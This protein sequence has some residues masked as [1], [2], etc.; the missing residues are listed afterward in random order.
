[1]LSNVYKDGII[2]E[3]FEK[4]G[5]ENLAFLADG[6][7]IPAGKL[8][9]VEC[10]CVLCQ[11][12]KIVQYRKALLHNPY[13]CQRCNFSGEKNPFFGKTHTD[14]FKKRISAERKAN[15]IGEKN[16]FFGKHHSP[17]SIAL[18]KNKCSN[19][20]EK[21]GFFGKTHT[22][23]TR[24]K[25]SLYRKNHPKPREYYSNMG[26][27]SANKRPKKTSIEKKVEKKLGE[28]GINHRYSFILHKKAQYDFLIDENILL[29]VHGDYWHGNPKVYSS[30][31]E[32]QLY[33]KSRDIEKESLAKENDYLYYVIWES[34]INTGNWSILNEI[35]TNRNQNVAKTTL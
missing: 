22:P 16:P 27:I 1:M 6:R 23:E 5:K 13:T 29:E 15:Y 3:K 19:W 14:E 8:G 30:F 32:R 2:I 21:N 28:L 4:I 9:A 12:K 33:K 11:Q 34:D 31:N 10:E 26:T 18:L 25:M 24:E 17:A 20:G 7:K 35:Q